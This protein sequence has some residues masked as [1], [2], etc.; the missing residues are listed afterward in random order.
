MPASTSTDDR[1]ARDPR[2]TDVLQAERPASAVADTAISQLDRIGAEAP[3]L[4]WVHF[5]DA[6]APYAP[7]ADARQRAGGDAYNGEIAYVDAQVE[8]LLAAI[9][10]RADAARTAVVVVGDH[11]ESLGE[12]GEPTHGMLLFEPALRV[13]LIVRAPGVAPAERADAAS[14]VD[15]APTVMAI[16]GVSAAATPGRSLLD[17]PSTD[18]ET[19]AESEYPTV[20][21]WTPV[22]ALIRERWKLVASSTPKLFDL[23]ADPGELSDVVGNESSH[24]EGDDRPPGRDPGAPKRPPRGR[25]PG[26]I[27]GNGGAIAIPRLRGAERRD[28]ARHGRRGCR[29]RDGC[30]GLVRSRAR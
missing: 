4:L 11:G 23:S 8:R 1:I 26:G 28:G 13:P 29:H 30:V 10:R 24:D 12:H 22:R 14:L 15:I 27:G 20:A 18:I 6:H 5:Y 3:W 17:L 7:P 16:A 19:Y 9:D 2:A 21:A 25:R